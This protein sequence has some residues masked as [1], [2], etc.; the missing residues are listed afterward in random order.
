MSCMILISIL[1]GTYNLYLEFFTPLF[2]IFIPT[3]FPL[4]HDYIKNAFF[5]NHN[6]LYLGRQ[7]FL[8]YMCPSY[9]SFV[10]ADLTYFFQR[11]NLPGA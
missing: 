6:F 4:T 7:P 5:Q 10:P 3:S 2:F 11:E 1:H 8:M 9:T